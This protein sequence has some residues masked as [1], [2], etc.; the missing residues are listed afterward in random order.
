MVRELSY[1]TS[2]VVFACLL[3]SA[4]F[5]GA[6]CADPDVTG[7]VI[8]IIGS[9]ECHEPIDWELIVIAEDDCDGQVEVSVSAGEDLDDTYPE[10]GD[11]EV[12][13]S[14]RDFAGNQTTET[15]TISVVDTTPPD[16][17][18]CAF[19]RTVE[20]TPVGGIVT[21]TVPDFESR[22]F[23]VSDTCDKYLTVTQLCPAGTLITLDLNN[24]A[25]LPARH[26]FDIEVEDDSGNI[27]TC[28]ACVTLI[29][30]EEPVIT[31][32]G[33]VANDV[34]YTDTCTNITPAGGECDIWEC[35]TPYW[36]MVWECNVP[37]EDWGALA[38]AYDPVTGQDLT[39]YMVTT[40][41]QTNPAVGVVDEIDSELGNEYT[42]E[43]SV[44]FNGYVT[45]V[46]RHVVIED[47]AAPAISLNSL[48]GISGAY[49]LVIHPHPTENDIPEWRETA[50]QLVEGI[51]G[52][53]HAYFPI[54]IH[55]PWDNATAM[56]WDCAYLPYEDPGMEVDDACGG[57]FSYQD[58]LENTLAILVLV[59]KDEKEYFV[60]GEFL[61][62]IHGDFPLLAQP[63]PDDPLSF[64]G[65]RLYL[66]VKDEQDNIGWMSR[67]ILPYYDITF[68]LAEPTT[69]FLTCDS[70][71]DDF[72]YDLWQSE[73]DDRAYDPCMGDVSHALVSSGNVTFDANG[74]F[75]P[76]TYYREYWVNGFP[77]YS[78]NEARRTI[79]VEETDPDV[80]LLN[81]DGTELK[82]TD[83]VLVLPWC[84]FL[85]YPGATLEEQAF[86]WAQDWWLALPDYDRED[87][88]FNGYYATHPCDDDSLLTSQI[89]V[90]GVRQLQDAM[91]AYEQ[92]KELSLLGVYGIA[93]SL[94]TPR[95][96]EIVKERRV[97]LAPDIEAV[98]SFDETVDVISD[99]GAGNAVIEVSCGASFNLP[100]VDS[101]QDACATPPVD[102]PYPITTVIYDAEGLPVTLAAITATAPAVFYIEYYVTPDAEVDPIKLYTVEV[103]VVVGGA[104]AITLTG[105]NP[106]VVECASA[107]EEP[108]A[109]AIGSC[110]EDISGDIVID[111]SAVDTGILGAHQVTY[112]VTDLEGNAA[113]QVV[114]TV[115]VVD[116]TAPV[117]VLT[118]LNPIVVGCAGTYTE[119][120]AT[121]IDDCAGDISADIVIDSSAINIGVVGAYQ[122][123]YNVMDPEGNVA[124]EVI[125]TVTVADTTVPTIELLGANPMT[126]ECG[127]EYIEVGGVAMDDCYDDISGDIVI[128]SSAVDTTIVGT[129]EVTYN[130]TDSEGN[131]A[132]EVVRT[133]NVVDTTR[134]VI[135]L[136]GDNP[137]TVECKDT[138]VEPGATA[139][140]TCFGDISEDVFVSGD[141]VDTSVVGTYTITYN[142]TDAEENI[143]HEVR[144]VVNVVDNAGP[145]VILLGSADVVVECGSK[146]EDEGA[147][148]MDA[149]E[150]NVT[151]T[152]VVGGDEVDTGVVG[153][154]VVTYTAVDS[155]SNTGSANRTVTVVDTTPPVISKCG[156]G[157]F[158]EVDIDGNAIVPNFLTPV[159]ATDACDIRNLVLSQSPMAGALITPP[160]TPAYYPVEITV[161]DQNGNESTCETWL[162]ILD[163]TK[164]IIVMNQVDEIDYV[165]G[166]DGFYYADATSIWECGVAYDDARAIAYDS[167]DGDL[168]ESMVVEGAYL[169]DAAILG[170]EYDVVYS[171]ENSR[172]ATAQAVRH[173]IIED[174]ARPV[175]SL[176]AL[177]GNRSGSTE[178]EVN[179]AQYVDPDL[180]DMKWLYELKN[181][182]NPP[183]WL[184]ELPARF[185]AYDSPAWDDDTAMLWSCDVPYVDPG[186]EVVDLCDGVLNSDETVVVVVRVQKTTADTAEGEG[187]VAPT[188]GEAVST[189]GET[190]Q[191][192]Y[193]ETNSNG[194]NEEFIWGGYY[195]ELNAAQIDLLNATWYYDDFELYGYRIY[196]F[197]K[198]S[199]GKQGYLSRHVYPAYTWNW[200]SAGED[201]IEIDCG[202]ESIFDT[203][204][205]LEQQDRYLT[206]CMG[207]VSHLIERSGDIDIYT[208]GEYRRLYTR[209]GIDL[210]WADRWGQVW[211]RT[212]V[213]RDTM[214]EIVLLDESGEALPEDA[215]ITQVRLCM[216]TDMTE[217][218][219]EAYFEDWWAIEPHTGFYVEDACEDTE[220]LTSAALVW[221]DGLLADA[222]KLFA[223]DNT[224]DIKDIW[225]LTYSAKDSLNNQVNTEREIVLIE[226]YDIAL[227][228]G[229]GS[230]LTPD[231]NDEIWI[232]VECGDSFALPEYEITSIC[233]NRV[234]EVEVSVSLFD[235]GDNPIE[236]I[237]TNVNGTYSVVYTVT[238][239]Y[240]NPTI[241]T[242]Y[243]EVVDTQQPMF[244]MGAYE[245]GML[246][247]DGFLVLE[248]STAMT[249]PA[250]FM[251]GDACDVNLGAVQ[252]MLDENEAGVMAYAWALDGDLEPLWNDTE[253]VTLAYDA[254]ASVPGDYLLIYYA[255]D[256]SGNEY[257]VLDDD[258]IPPIFDL[259]GNG[260]FLNGDGELIVDFAR[261]VRVVDTLVPVITLTGEE[262]MTVECGGTLE[263][264]G[265]TA[266]DECDGELTVVVTDNVLTGTPGEYQLMYN[267]QD[268][269]GNVAVSVTRT[270]YIVDTTI[271]VIALVGDD[272]LTLE[273]GDEPGV[274]VSASDSCDGDL[275]TSVTVGGD[276]AIGTAVGSY[277]QTFNVMDASGNA[278]VEVTRTVNV[279]DTTIPVITLLGDAEVTVACGDEYTDAGVT[280]TDTC[281]GDLSEDVTVGGDEVDT[282]VPGS[283]MITYN[284]VDTSANAAV[285]VTRTVVVQDN[286]VEGEGE[287]VEGEGEVAEG[288]ASEG[289][290]SEGETSEGETTEGE[291]SEGEATEGETSEGEATEGEAAEGETGEVAQNLLDLYDQM[292]ANDDGVLSYEEAQ[293]LLQALSQTQFNT[294]DSN[295]DGTVTREELLSF[296][297]PDGISSVPDVVGL[298]YQEAFAAILNAGLKVGSVSLQFSDTVPENLII[299]QDPAA[300][301]AV[302][303]NEGVDLVQSKGPEY[304]EPGCG[305]SSCNDEDTE[306]A[307][308]LLQKLISEWLLVGI[309]MLG[310]CCWK[311]I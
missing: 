7:P 57:E 105:D 147:T 241:A 16:I 120:G 185:S 82:E 127:D 102:L 300:G 269:A 47:D 261:L 35:Q 29:D 51:P 199:T 37:F 281:N 311:A 180:K 22:M 146:F 248:C 50:Y 268:A 90:Y 126:V 263:D 152:I 73:L 80:Y 213:V 70:D 206:S 12:D 94:I 284:V 264:P 148:A 290:T 215:Q 278:A 66:F 155:T 188:E 46:N 31:L 28:Q 3:L 122:V 181:S 10:L 81:E 272:P 274:D 194:E 138:Y 17:E 197:I 24:D 200:I 95:S 25:T 256:S 21:Y 130:V 14:A 266:A 101:L 111:S 255:V 230:P 204:H 48:S 83:P 293:A 173:V 234:P 257:P 249:E 282:S 56:P 167:V 87:D 209:P 189:E 114:R 289:E 250:D 86:N 205:E 210:W 288:E 19:S 118:G 176:L 5:A 132:E 149:C 291:T 110:N 229:S 227:T 26:C 45:T 76:G 223:A 299:S 125:R 42:I 169:V 133:V 253:P 40:I 247:E 224:Y 228:D 62:A 164:P 237:N 279:T 186:L 159:V 142:V 11:Y 157:L 13:F 231:I 174:R 270:V 52:W 106:L 285:E 8:T 262:T 131:A 216:F 307:K 158:V 79:I 67:R 246:D 303:L 165:L 191:P 233:T 33:V 1:I 202:D 232:T 175:F 242:V 30:P 27:S 97:F 304:E 139:A 145:V 203:L 298:E 280:A 34:Q 72:Y 60:A 208:P 192:E 153:V 140:D 59:D 240:G 221:G 61:E 292:D 108:G 124:I 187:E 193:D 32:N 123:T 89:Q 144:R 172:G 196:Y 107:Y 254:F 310:L 183:W 244:T 201:Y 78:G 218:E 93:Y 156:D 287:A 178:L 71:V 277:T 207:D 91:V 163:T 128:D 18:Q 104:P 239:Q 160:T 55:E 162:Q 109:T 113:L 198:D 69:I 184:N 137:L 267:A 129:Y 302:P 115:N 100:V 96:G 170:G 251:A 119:M 226:D 116:T 141:I 225:K 259:E 4:S 245:E 260:N 64:L 220:I 58:I 135:T 161:A 134:P 243:V 297:Y 41:T 65:Y 177:E 195:D 168:T 49:P 219:I 44:D 212:I 143:A 179:Y 54:F 283:Y 84:D 20:V 9:G 305:C 121:A 238:D 190:Q 98:L 2:C 265:A 23:F 309:A 43:Y 273:C 63:D 222:L 92:T 171:V 308:G 151:N 53:E 75:V 77:I 252:T 68:D 295:Q 38:Y 74:R 271:P 296:L 103:D 211:K 306:D 258:D 236:S 6:Q 275:T 154:Y 88:I 182:P 99:D 85:D 150:G 136:V 286:C 112:D 301:T 276:K 294:L 235:E 166:E 15:L 117:I 39:P 214:P 217:P 36:E